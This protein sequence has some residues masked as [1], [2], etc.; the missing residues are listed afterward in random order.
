MSRIGRRLQPE[1]TCLAFAECFY[2]CHPSVSSEGATVIISELRK[3]GWTYSPAP[4]VHILVSVLFQLL[5]ATPLC[6]ASGTTF[7]YAE[8]RVK[9]GPG[10]SGPPSS[11][12][13]ALG[14]FWRRAVAAMGTVPWGW[15]IFICVSTVPP[16]NTLIQQK[17]LVHSLVLLSGNPTG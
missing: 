1:S 11:S 8:Q 5:K 12:D 2:E 14:T 17:R 7:T 13:C 6:T 16:I 4:G 10:Y 9:G 3:G 15:E